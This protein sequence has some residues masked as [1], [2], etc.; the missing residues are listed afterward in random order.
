MSLLKKNNQAIRL[1]APSTASTWYGQFPCILHREH[2]KP[3][4]AS[5]E[6]LWKILPAR[7][8]CQTLACHIYM[9]AVVC[10]P[11]L[12]NLGSVVVVNKDS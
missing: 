7:M 12:G 5:P 2:F 10:K 8:T 1:S 4:A 11:A 3:V 9:A 6:W